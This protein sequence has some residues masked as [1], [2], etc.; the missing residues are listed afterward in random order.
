[1]IAPDIVDRVTSLPPGLR[2]I[3]RCAT[4][5]PR[6]CWGCRRFNRTTRTHWTRS[7]P[8]TL[9]SRICSRARFRHLN[10]RRGNRLN[11]GSGRIEG[12]SRGGSCPQPARHSSTESTFELPPLGAIIWSEQG[13]CLPFAAHTPGAA[14][15]VR[16]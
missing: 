12:T 2:A 13:Q 4:Q 9:W 14:N 1:L 5:S 11:R 8:A 6:R 7:V 16:Q 15:P 10:A 3:R